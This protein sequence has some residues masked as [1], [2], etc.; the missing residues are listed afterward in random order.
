M[1]KLKIFVGMLALFALVSANM[2]NAKT[3][4][5]TVDL[6]A[7]D[8]EYVAEGDVD[9]APSSLKKHYDEERYMCNVYSQ[10]TFDSNG[11]YYTP[12]GTCI[13]GQPFQTVTICV[14]YIAI[15][16][17]RDWEMCAY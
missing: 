14:S 1:A 4:F 11:C 3:T 6:E 17:V 8:V 15:R 9:N 12:D 10:V 5:K 2:W 16:C 7:A 13:H